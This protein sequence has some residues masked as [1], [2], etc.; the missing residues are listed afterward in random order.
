[1]ANSSFKIEVLL[2][3]AINSS[4][5]YLSMHQKNENLIEVFYLIAVHVPHDKFSS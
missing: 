3:N 2:E 1:M 4:K 5:T